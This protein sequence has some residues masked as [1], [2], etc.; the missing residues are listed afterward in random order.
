[1]GWCWRKRQRSEL[2]DAGGAPLTRISA[3]LRSDLS[4]KERG[5]ATRGPRLVPARPAGELGELCGRARPR[6]QEALHL[7]A[8]LDAQLLELLDRLDGLGRGGDAECGRKARDGLDDRLGVAIV[9]VTHEGAVDLDLV[10]GELAQIAEPRIARAEIVHGDLHA[11]FAQLEQHLHIAG[12]VI[13]QHILGD[14][15]LEA[16]RLQP[17]I[18]ERPRSPPARGCGCGTAPGRC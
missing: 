18:G 2:R 9:Q 16:L 5:W 6:D 4:R 15:E 12:R 7:V 14:L 1:M 11:A 17:R 8:T 10:E 3:S 13:Q